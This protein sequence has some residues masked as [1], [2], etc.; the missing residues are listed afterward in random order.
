MVS[1]SPP[2]TLGRCNRRGKRVLG[3]QQVRLAKIRGHMSDC[4]G[5]VRRKPWFV[6]Q[7]EYVEVSTLEQRLQAV[8]RRMVARPTPQQ[9]QGHRQPQMSGSRPGGNMVVGKPLAVILQFAFRKVIMCMLVAGQQGMPN[10]Q[11]GYQPGMPQQH[12]KVA[13][14]KQHIQNQRGMNLKIMLQISEPMI[15]SC[16]CPLYALTVCFLVQV[17]EVCLLSR[18]KIL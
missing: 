9:Q 4:G 1:D 12:S 14:H 18:C 7:E 6:V 15:S 13:Q 11:A 2:T 5:H 16:T 8:A 3:R 10:G 17:V